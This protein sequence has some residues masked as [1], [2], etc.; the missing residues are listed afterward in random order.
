MGVG[1]LY[2]LDSLGECGGIN[3][4]RILSRA[5][6]DSGKRGKPK[7]LQSGL[8][9]LLPKPYGDLGKEGLEGR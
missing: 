3:A 2:R 4:G 5:V 9:V 8:G 6:K 7:L 1:R